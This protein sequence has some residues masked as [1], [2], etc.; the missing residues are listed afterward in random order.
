MITGFNT[1][2]EYEGVVYHVQTEDKGLESP[3]I[4]SLVYAGGAILASK[5][6]PYA[7]L[8][9]SGFDEQALAQRLK[10]QHRLICAAIN[11][12]RIDDLKR[13]G[14]R[15]DEKPEVSAPPLEIVN[16]ASDE[17][18]V[19]EPPPPIEIVDNASDYAASAESPASEEAG[20]PD[21]EIVTNASDYASV[22][23]TPTVVQQPDVEASAAEAETVSTGTASP[24]TVHDSRRDSPLGEAPQPE[25]LNITILDEQDFWA[26]GNFH[27]RIMVGDRVNQQE[28]PVVGATLS[29]KVLG[30][31]FRP[32]LYSVKT[33]RDG[34]A[35]VSAQIP[36]FTSGRAAILIRAAAIDGRST[37]TRRVIHAAK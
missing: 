34:V 3:L 9:A 37:E 13:M 14:D 24:Y 29:V 11:A 2:I 28:Q 23:A 12:G 19:S 36:R 1:D 30:T 31:T 33:E 17:A 10:R 22:L 20:T 18:A 32:Q 4:L 16:N 15:S 21:L 5:R 7:D 25:G 8:I 27:I 6:S 35:V 26:G